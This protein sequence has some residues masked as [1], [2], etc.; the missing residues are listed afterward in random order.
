MQASTSR[1]DSASRP[2][3]T[4]RASAEEAETRDYVTVMIQ[5]Q[6]FGVPALVVHD[7][8]EPAHISPIPLA[9]PEIA[10]ALNLR[11]QVVTAIDMRTRLGLET[12]ESGAGMCVV[13]EVDGV[14]YS[15]IVDAVG[16][17]L[18]LADDDIEAEPSNIDRAWLGVC[19]GV[20]RTEAG[21]LLLLQVDR[22][23]DLQAPEADGSGS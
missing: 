11:G 18:S 4:R 22:L 5:D 19:D 21:L 17:V 16:E 13:V 6:L 20:T 12:R 1:T 3:A 23:L 14:S 2:A 10:G 15:L 9:P 7:I 8:M